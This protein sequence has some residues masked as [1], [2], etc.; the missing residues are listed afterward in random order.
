MSRFGPERTQLARAVTAALDNSAAH[1]RYFLDNGTLLGLM[2][3]GAL[4]DCDDDF[5]LGILVAE[6]DF[7][8][9]WMRALSDTLVHELRATCYEVRIVSSYAQK[10][11]VFDPTHGSFPLVGER[12]GGADFHHVSVDIQAHVQGLLGV[13]IAHSDFAHRGLLPTPIYEPMGA[14][15]YSGVVWPVPQ[16]CQG[17]L[18]WLYGY[19]GHGAV[20][21]SVSKLYR[22][23]FDESRGAIR[24]YADMS[25]D[26][27][28]GGHVNYLR[29]LKCIAPDVRLVVGLHSDATI[30]S[31][32]RQPICTMEERIAVVEAC[33]Y[34]DHVVPDAPLHITAQF[35]DDHSIDV[36]AHGDQICPMARTAMYAVPIEMGRYT[37]VPR[38]EGISTTDLIQRVLSRQALKTLE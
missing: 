9:A 34:V 29:Q 26:L 13:R 32:K 22:K 23:E 4:I 8:P 19:V 25:A 5:D 38:T 24:V 7:S 36:V 28:H 16:D 2:R 20:Y 6:A 3:D 12:Y 35:M 11:E 14:L 17:F 18:A 10:I 31:Y 27:F 21:D 30:E 1:Y 15:S 33:V 37:E